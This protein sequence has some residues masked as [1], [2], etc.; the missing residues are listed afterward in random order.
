METIERSR[1]QV[2]DKRGGEKI[3]KSRSDETVEQSQGER[4]TSS[5]KKNKRT[6]VR[7]AKGRQQ[8]KGKGRNY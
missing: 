5:R 6:M 2:I 3:I 1:R 8:A 7:D 4:D